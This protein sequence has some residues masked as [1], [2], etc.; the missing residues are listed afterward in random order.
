MITITFN[1]MTLSI[2]TLTLL[3]AKTE[4]GRNVFITVKRSSLFWPRG[5]SGNTKGG[6]YHCTIDLLFDWFGLVCFANKNNNCQLSYS[7][8]QTS[9]TEGQQYSDTSPFSIPCINLFQSNY[10]SN[11]VSSCVCPVSAISTLSSI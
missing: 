4:Y 6:K 8:F 5:K 7:S 9:Q 1:I 3:V 10:L 11:I 2:M